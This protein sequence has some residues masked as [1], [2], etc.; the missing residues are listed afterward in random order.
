MKNASER[1][2][3]VVAHLPQRVGEVGVP[4]A[5][6]E[7][8]RQPDPVRGELGL[9]RR[10]QIAVLLVDRADA[11]EEL[12]VMA[13]LR[14]PLARDVASARDVLEERDHVVGPLG[15]AE[16]DDEQRVVATVV[17][18]GVGPVGRL[19]TRRSCVHR[20]QPSQRSAGGGHLSARCAPAAHRAAQ[21]ATVIRR[22]GVPERS[23]GAVLKTVGRASVPWV[24]IPP[25][26]LRSKGIV[27]S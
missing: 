4:V 27:G 18:P 15:A 17:E 22:G 12:V 25:P 26:P 7:V 21:P 19:L 8:D 10:D 3:P 24:Q 20:G 6:A 11:A 2:T 5:V 16:R 1:P 23:N 9:E 13:D 14:E